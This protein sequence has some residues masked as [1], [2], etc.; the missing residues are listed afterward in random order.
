M[1]D[2]HKSVEKRNSNCFVACCSWFSRTL[3]LDSQ[4]QPSPTIGWSCGLEGITRSFILAIFDPD[5]LWPSGNKYMLSCLFSEHAH[6]CWLHFSFLV[7]LAKVLSQEVINDTRIFDL[8][9]LQTFRGASRLNQ[10]KGIQ[11]NSIGEGSQFAKAYTRRDGGLCGVD[12]TI[13]TVYVLAGDIWQGKLQLGL[14][15]LNQER[16]T[17]SW[18]ETVECNNC[19]SKAANVYIVLF[20]CIYFLLFK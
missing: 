8:E 5:K 12:L 7:I 15:N 16:F 9:I 4:S 3:I 6:A 2:F 14:C 10:T 18:C 19:T 1:H 11:V 17:C 20:Y 13:G